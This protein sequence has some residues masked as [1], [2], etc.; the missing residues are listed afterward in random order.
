MRDLL[1]LCP[2][3]FNNLNSYNTI[4]DS[5]LDAQTH[6]RDTCIET[7]KGGQVRANWGA[8]RKKRS[9]KSQMQPCC[10]V[11]TV[12]LTPEKGGIKLCLALPSAG[13]SNVT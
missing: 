8:R 9:K 10:S 7:S 1:G 2:G 12:W 13:R 11:L 4:K 3:R 6:L 5:L